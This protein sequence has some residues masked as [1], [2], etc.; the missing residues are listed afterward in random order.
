MSS[1]RMGTYG[2][3]LIPVSVTTGLSG[4]LT[5]RIGPTGVGV[6]ASEPISGNAAVA[7][8]A[9]SCMYCNEEVD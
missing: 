1:Q 9:A 3:C 8:L 5:R 4:M 6:A 2:W 7:C